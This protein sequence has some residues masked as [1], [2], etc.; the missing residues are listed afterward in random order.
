MGRIAGQVSSGLSVILGLWWFVVLMVPTGWQHKKVAGYDFYFGLWKVEMT[1]GKIM[2]FLL[3]AVSGLS[4]TMK[5]VNKGLSEL[6]EG[7]SDLASMKQSWCSYGSWG[8]CDAITSVWSGSWVM[9]IFGFVGVVFFFLGAGFSHYYWQTEAR[10]EPRMWARVAFI[11]AP[12]STLLGLLIYTFC[13]MG[14]GDLT[15]LPTDSRTAAFSTAFLFAWVL[16]VLSFIPLVL[17]EVFAGKA[18]IEGHNEAA[19]EYR[20]DQ[21]EAAMDSAYGGNDGYNSYGATAPM[22]APMGGPPM[23]NQENWGM[24]QQGGGYGYQGN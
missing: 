23:Q 2:G 20:H 3:D 1:Q 16:A 6:T 17:H 19:A 9:G 7:K 22:G 10:E 13:T 5:K 4:D 12:S 21:R 8:G 11:I 24:Q 15:V 14:L 18:W